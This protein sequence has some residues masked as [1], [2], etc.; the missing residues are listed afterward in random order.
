MKKL[1]FPKREYMYD[2][3]IISYKIAKEHDDIN[4]KPIIVFINTLFGKLDDI[5]EIYTCLHAKYNIIGTDLIHIVA[6]DTA[7]DEMLTIP[8]QSIVI[9][10]ILASCQITR[11]INF[12]SLCYGSLA[13][14]CYL[15][16][17]PAPLP[18][19]NSIFCSGIF[20]G[21]E[22]SVF[23]KLDRF[24]LLCQ[25]NEP[26]KGLVNLYDDFFSN[27]YITKKKT[28]Y[29]I[30]KKLYLHY[31]MDQSKLRCLNSLIRDEYNYLKVFTHTISDYQEILDPIKMY[32]LI[33]DK[34]KIVNVQM[35][36]DILNDWGIK[37][38]I[39]SCTGHA[40]HIEKFDEFIRELDL[41]LQNV[42]R[43]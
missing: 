2:N 11:Q 41:W 42:D 12:V 31:W 22:D 28:E 25:G 27:D 20:I 26:E 37:Y 18:Q 4:G 21:Y 9:Q 13:L 23:K 14:L 30:N 33:A 15:K 29:L 24:L 35:Q 10:K 39:L 6:Q 36:T 32:C 1:N 19:I 34:D 3:K 43:M 16:D 17:H 7:S 8:E 38:R 40:I 5:N